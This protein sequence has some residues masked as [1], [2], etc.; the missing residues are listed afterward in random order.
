MRTINKIV[1]SLCFLLVAASSMAETRES[2]T[3]QRIDR[4]VS[5]RVF[6]PKG[7]WMA[8]GTVSYSEHEES[9]LN[10]M[11]LKDFESDGYT[12]A[13]SPYFG[14]F[15]KDNMAA[16]LR[17]AYHRTYMDLG[18]LDI[19]LGGLEINLNEVYYL[20]HKYE[21]TGFFRSYMAI[22][23]SKIFG[24]FNEMRLS[25]GYGQ[26][27]NSTGKGVDY[28]GTYQTIQ[29]LK[30]GFAP[31]LTAFITNRASAEVSIGVMG[32]DF[33]WIDQKTNQVE[34]GRRRVSS[35]NF[36][37]NLFSIN[38]GMTLYL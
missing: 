14:Y 36:K 34:T 30:I 29:N 7:S 37:I 12:F 3:I 8:G 1:V 6:I 16:G 23:N 5:K 33:K 26:G 9:N 22:G 20:E 27:K 13:L 24:L 19:N 4:E 31:G 18:N 11:V 15:F 38:L 35:G 10:F 2:R 28:D 32:F 17:F 25:Y 21:T